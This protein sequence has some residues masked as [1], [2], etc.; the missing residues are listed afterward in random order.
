LGFIAISIFFGQQLIEGCIHDPD[1]D[2]KIEAIS[3]VL[4]KWAKLFKEYITQQENDGDDVTI[5]VNGLSK[6][7]RE[8]TM[9]L[10]GL[11]VLLMHTFKSWAF[12]SLTLSQT[13]TSGLITKRN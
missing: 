3:P 1:F 6:K 5:I 10:F 7:Q 8:F 12:S 2:D 9:H 13:M 4:L 11:L